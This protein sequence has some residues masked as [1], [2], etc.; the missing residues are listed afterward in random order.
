MD[1]EPK[2][3]DKGGVVVSEDFQKKTHE[4]VHKA[5]KHE[6]HHVRDRVYD[7]EDALRKE[8]ASKEPKKAG[9]YPEVMS[10]ADMPKG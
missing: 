8:E 10:T 1:N 7:R 4:L 6:L 5:T 2:M 3:E 9:K